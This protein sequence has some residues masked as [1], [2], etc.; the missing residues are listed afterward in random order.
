[1]IGR[2]GVVLFIFLL[3]PSIFALPAEKLAQIWASKFIDEFNLNSNQ[4]EKTRGLFI[5]EIDR[6]NATVNDPG[7]NFPPR[8]AEGLAFEREIREKLNEILDDNQREKLSERA[9]PVLPDAELVRLN[10]RLDLD[11]KQ[12]VAI[13]A[14]L[15]SHRFRVQQLRSEKSGNA[16]ENM[17]RMKEL[18]DERDSRIEEILNDSQKSKFRELREEKRGES[19]RRPPARGGRPGRGRG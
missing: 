9:Y 7:R 6:M 5:E 3:M 8:R 1:M 4:A 15:A 14:I 2:L 13:E 10:G 19:G 11:E 12:V 16:E 18:R 17:S